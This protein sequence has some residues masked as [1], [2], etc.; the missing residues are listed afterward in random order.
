MRAGLL[1][2]AKEHIF[3]ILKSFQLFLT[4]ALRIL[5]LFH[6]IGP[7]SHRSYQSIIDTPVGTCA[8]TVLGTM[9]HILSLRNSCLLAKHAISLGT[10]ILSR[11]FMGYFSGA[12]DTSPKSCLLLPR[13][14]DGSVAFR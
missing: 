14:A 10:V 2:D 8:S 13:Y 11:L 9:Q 7:N 12:Q 5:V 1:G 6:S 3:M 4:F